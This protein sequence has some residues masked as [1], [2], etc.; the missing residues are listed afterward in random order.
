MATL[1]ALVVTAPLAWHLGDEIYGVPGDATGAVATFWWWG[2]ALVH[3]K[4]ILDNTLQGVP[5]GSE[6]DLIAF[7]PL[8]V[9]LFTPLSALLGPIVSYNLLILSGFPLTAWATYLLGRQLGITKLGAAFAGLALA[10][11][12][13]HIEKAMAHGNQTHLEF[14]ASALLFLVRWRQGGGWRNLVLAGVFAGLQ[15]SWEPSVAYV[16]VFALIA[17][18]VV[19]GALPEGG[20][21]R[22]S[23]V[24]RHLEGGA[25]MAA[26][27]ALFAPAVLLFLHRP[28]G[29][30]YASS[31]TAHITH[32]AS[33]TQAVYYS[34]RLREYFLP[35]HANP[36]LPAALKQWEMDH[37]HGSDFTESSLF[38]GFTVLVLAL[39]GVL[40]ARKGF[41]IAL[42]ISLAALGVVISLAPDVKIGPVQIPMPSHFLSEIVTVFRVYARFAMMVQLGTC[43][44]AG[45]GFA[46]LQ[47]RLG[48]GRRALLL[49][50][51]FVLMAVEFNNLPPSHVTQ[52]LPAP[53]EYVWL[54]DQPAGVV[55]EYPANAGT[56][57][58]QEVDIR[59]YLLYQMVHV[60]P[61]FL[62]EVTNGQVSDVA[63]SLE[64]YYGPGV[65]DKLK[66]YGVRYVLVHRSDYIADGF[67]VP[68]DVSGL[69]YV[70]S[71]D[72][73][74]IYTVT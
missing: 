10:F 6:W 22:M 40:W 28:G 55:M 19:S 11:M 37:L 8:P 12:P 27:A 44:L 66:A 65:A 35:W 64:P 36:L 62:T 54:R 3:G 47:G 46:V 49:A 69:T 74:D 32:A 31:L 60:H 23:W 25:V 61:T 17:F 50:V 73:V 20:K 2:Y 18:F 13:Y 57:Y 53:A 26:V 5:L 58:G 33:S 67:E 71:M 51:P 7:S 30:D 1:W 16:M 48:S 59:Q 34:A 24:V 9:V 41:P 72:G 42:G 29:S 63:R 45:L 4:P 14:L 39:I 21:S 56:P 43:L 70:T 15:A 52:V 68:R 38:L